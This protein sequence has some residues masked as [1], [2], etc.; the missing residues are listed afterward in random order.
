MD[1][2]G[3]QATDFQITRAQ[4]EALFNAGVA[5][6]QQFLAGKGR[7]VLPGTQGYTP[8]PLTLRP[9]SASPVAPR[10]MAMAAARGRTL[11]PAVSPTL[12]ADPPANPLVWN[13][14][15]ITLVSLAI[16]AVLGL[17]IAVLAGAIHLG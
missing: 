7:G 5:A 10:P 9:V 6:A 3:I 16:I 1:S 13:T 2:L 17:L 14:L 12:T 8:A 4:S 11:A 15:A